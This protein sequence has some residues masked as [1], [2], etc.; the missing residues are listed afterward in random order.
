[1]VVM[2]H[3]SWII[4]MVIRGR[5]KRLGGS[6]SDDSFLTICSTWWEYRCSY[7]D[8]FYD[9][10]CTS[11]ACNGFCWYCTWETQNWTDYFYWDGSNAVFYGEAYSDSLVS[12]GDLFP[13]YSSTAWWDA[14]AAQWYSLGPYA[15]TVS[16][17]GDGSG[18]VSSSPAGIGC[19]GTCQASFDA[20]TGVTLTATPDTSSIFTGWS[21]D[22][23]GTGSCQVT[24]DHA[25]GDRELRPEA[26]PTERPSHGQLHRR[27]CGAQL[28]SGRRRVRRP[29]RDDR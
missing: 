15:L 18:E 20:G 10:P 6:T 23:T 2:C 4:V 7:E 19:G 28:Q 24:M 14:P 5:P 17:Q 1:M 11:G 25:L 16:K 27:L 26:A 3:V 9:N 12:E 29:G 8:T 22:C 21:G 13:P